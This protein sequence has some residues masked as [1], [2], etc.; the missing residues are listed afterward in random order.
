MLN[1]VKAEVTIEP[2][3]AG[4]LT[5]F[6]Q[7]FTI[8]TLLFDIPFFSWAWKIA[9]IFTL[10]SGIDYFLRGVKAINENIESSHS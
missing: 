4:K 1:F 5:T 3:L 8:L 7:M 6:F 2:T 9:A 10:I